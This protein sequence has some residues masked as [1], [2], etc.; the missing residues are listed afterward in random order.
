MYIPMFL[1]MINP[2]VPMCMSCRDFDIK[3]KT[4]F[5]RVFSH[6]S[7]ANI[8]KYANFQTFILGALSSLYYYKPYIGDGF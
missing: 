3:D 1:G 6:F 5:L 7:V 2:I 4:H 8:K